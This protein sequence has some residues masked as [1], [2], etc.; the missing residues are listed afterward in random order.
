MSPEVTP[1]QAPRLGPPAADQ[2]PRIAEDTVLRVCLLLLYPLLTVLTGTSCLHLREFQ[3]PRPLEDPD[4]P[5]GLCSVSALRARV[6]LGRWTVGPGTPF[7]PRG[8]Q[9]HP[10]PWSVLSC[11]WLRPSKGGEVAPQN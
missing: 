6:L 8:I 2:A 10:C 5:P 9:P 7:S 1:R 3:G 11:C 4:F